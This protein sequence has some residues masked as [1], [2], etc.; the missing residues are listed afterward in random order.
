LIDASEFEMKKGRKIEADGG[1]LYKRAND[2]FVKVTAEDTG[3]AYEICEERCPPGFASRRHMHTE[4]HET[5]FIIEGS[6]TFELGPE[7]FDAQP[8]QLYHIP[9]KVP[10]KVT[11]G[12][13]GV[14][15]LMVYSPGTT[16]AMFQDM[17]ALSPEQRQDFEIGKGVAAKHN[18]VWVGGD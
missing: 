6:A 2:M 3:G 17:V 10:H 16:E 4:N 9:P 18:T 11:A 7:T 5:F 15:M 14:R 13:D 1:N 8:G 12:A